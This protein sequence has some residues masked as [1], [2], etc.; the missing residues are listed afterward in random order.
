MIKPAIVA[1]GYNRP[2]GIRRLLES[3]GRAKYEYNDIA[4]I[5]SIDE[6]NKSDEVEKVAQ[7]FEW[8][9]G[10]KEI[11][12]FPERQGLRKHIVQCGDLSEKYGGVIILEDDLIVSEDFYTYVCKAHEAYSNN[13][14]VCGVA[15]YS[16]SYN[17]F[18][19]YTFMPTPT[20]CDVYLGGMVVTWGQSWTHDQWVNF[21]NWYLAHEDKLPALNP[22]IPRDISS[23]TRSW[24]RYFAS[25]MAE[26]GLSYVYPKIARSTCFSDFGEHNKTGLPF[27]FV[28]VPLMHGAPRD[29]HFGNLDEL[30]RFDAFYER[31]LTKD[32]KIAG[33]SGNLICMDLNNMKNNAD[34]KEYVITNQKLPLTKVASFGLTL[35]PIALN[36]IENVPGDQLFMY[37]INVSEN[38]IRPWDGKRPNYPA[39]L[40]RLKYEYHDAPWRSLLY[41]A[42]REF[43]A[44]VKDQIKK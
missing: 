25:Y 43:Y 22:K 10:T 24:G 26:K 36:V 20:D 35:R 11:R 44:R 17:V 30:E 18:T 27:T 19:H 7:Q 32:E 29:Y 15:L 4:L 39:D 1:V 16:Y 23:W 14:E 37:K 38:T 34:G 40:R 21:K 12:R 6:S 42:P 2:D 28:Q 9:Y 8:K 5:V 41:Y 33:I 13:K 3:I 31:V